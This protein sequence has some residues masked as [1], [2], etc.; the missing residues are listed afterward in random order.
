MGEGPAENPVSALFS[1]LCM[2]WKLD[3]LHGPIIIII[4]IIIIK[5]LIV[6]GRDF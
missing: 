3:I 4:I 5:A 1:W 2:P 6:L